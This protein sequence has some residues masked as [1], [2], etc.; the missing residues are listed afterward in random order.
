MMKKNKKTERQIKTNLIKIRKPLINKEII[1]KSDVL[2][3]K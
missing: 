3:K 1:K 2:P